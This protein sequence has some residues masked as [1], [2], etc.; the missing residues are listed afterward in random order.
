MWRR[1]F[2][3]RQGREGSTVPT[4]QV[5]Q[6]DGYCIECQRFYL[7]RGLGAGPFEDVAKRPKRNVVVLPIMLMGTLETCIGSKIG[8]QTRRGGNKLRKEH[9]RLLPVSMTDEY[10]T[11]KT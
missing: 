10:Q 5:P 11:S 1:R 9:G 7:P 4:G 3:S 6:V 2:V 8:G